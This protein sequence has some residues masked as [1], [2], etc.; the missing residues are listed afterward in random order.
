MQQR[1]QCQQTQAPFSFKAV[2]CKGT[3]GYA[4][5][6]SAFRGEQGLAA[7]SA[8]SRPSQLG[9]CQRKHSWVPKPVNWRLLYSEYH[10]L[11]DN[12]RSGQCRVDRW[13]SA[14]QES[15]YTLQFDRRNRL[16]TGSRDNT[17][18]V[19]HLSEA[20]SQLTPLATLRGHTGSVLTLHAEGSMLVT[21]SSDS[22]VCVWSTDTYTIRQRLAHPDAVLS[23][24]FNDRWLATACK[25]GVVRVWR[26]KQQAFAEPF[27][28]EGHAVAINAVHLHGDTLVSASGDRTIRVWDLAARSCTMTLAG[29]ARGVACVDFDGAYIVSGSSD[30]TIR[31]WNATT[32]RCE[33]TISSAHSDLVRTVMLNRNMDVMVS[34]SYDETIKIWRLS[35]GAL[36]HK[37]K[38][39]HTSRVFK[40][41]FDRSRIV[42]CS[43]DRSISIIDFAAELPHARLLL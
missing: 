43:H 22:D 16:F 24:R 32:G 38:N 27:E 33:R 1:Q 8:F 31:I 19:W 39:V 41:M 25:D 37:I 28:L 4:P 11:L 42:S 36:I 15:I 26:R 13:E 17:V 30:R 21:G 34:G 10:S 29:H 23:L 2:A 40:L 35:T 7:T 9:A 14:H 18:K 3:I 6:L 20:G 5:S 12:W